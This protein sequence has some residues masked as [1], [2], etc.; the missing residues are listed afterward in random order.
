MAAATPLQINYLSP[1]SLCSCQITMIATAIIQRK[2]IR[3]LPGEGRIAVKVAMI[4]VAPNVSRAAR[5]L[6]IVFILF[7]LIKCC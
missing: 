5:Y 2:S 6:F 7:T 4:M 3:S 1:P